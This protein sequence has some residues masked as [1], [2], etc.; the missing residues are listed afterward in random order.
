[1]KGKKWNI[2]IVLGFAGAFFGYLLWKEGP[3]QLANTLRQAD[4]RWLLLCLGLMVGYWVLEAGILHLAVRRFYPAQ[5][6]STTFHTAMV[7]QFFN[8]ITPFASGGQPMQACHMVVTGVPLGKASSALMMKFII[9]QFVLT[10]YSGVTLIWKFSEFS[11]HVSGLSWLVLVGFGV[12]LAVILGLLGVC[13]ASP[14]AKA[15][16]NW[17]IGKLARMGLVKDEAA[18][19]AFWEKELDSFYQSFRSMGKSRGLVVQMALLSAVQLTC[20][21][22]VPY[23]IF[24]SF[25]A[26]FGLGKGSALSMLAAEAF[27]LNVSS[28]VPLPGASGGAE[29]SFHAMFAMFF[30]S[31]CLGIS[32]LLWRLFTFYLP[33]L[34][35][36]GFVSR[37]RRENAGGEPGG[38]DAPSRE[39]D[40]QAVRLRLSA[41]RGKQP[42]RIQA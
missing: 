5:R 21:F 25:G 17:L 8:C 38:P 23:G 14:K 40:P 15:L 16:G 31:A 19:R 1:M 29:L 13:F 10:V 26:A 42:D 18:A 11:A 24:R 22:L 28:F 9:Y 37:F 27:V 4:P 34:A 12:N 39:P 20:F 36:L 2:A 7:G 41:P 33:I 6:F 35:G 3:A 32:V 30:P